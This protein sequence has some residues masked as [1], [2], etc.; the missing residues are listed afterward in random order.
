MNELKRLFYYL[1]II[2]ILFLSTNCSDDSSDPATINEAEVLEKYLEDNGN[3]INTFGQMIPATTVNTNITTGTD[4]T[5][6][7]IRSATDYSAGHIKNAVN[8]NATEVLNYYEQHNLSSKE[9]VVIACYTGQTAAWVTGLMHTIGYTNVKDLAFGMSSWNSA[10]SSSWANGIGNSRASQLTK[11]VTP[12]AAEG[13]LPK[14]NTG[15][16]EATEIL[17]ARVEAVFAEGFG[18]AKIT[19]SAVFDNTSNYYIVNYWSESDYNWGHI[20]GAIQYTPKVDLNLNTNLKTIPT[21][22]VVTIY[23]YTGQT[24][25]HVAAYLRVLGYDAKTI[26]FGVNAMAHDTMPGTAFNAQSH[27]H[28]YE[29]VQ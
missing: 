23:C 5:V 8:V 15:K 17:R 9:V 7:D 12:K 18:G 29:L 6:I 22:K 14:L 28:N 10:T 3:P 27:V 1:L 4:Q 25:A 11:D 13:E 21:D 2:P 19:N 20:P 24:S 16:T 26:V